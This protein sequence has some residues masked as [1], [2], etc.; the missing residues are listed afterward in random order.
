M[1]AQLFRHALA[2]HHRLHAIG[3]P[4]HA[5][6][7]AL[8]QQ[9]FHEGGISEDQVSISRSEEPHGGQDLAD[10]RSGRLDDPV[11]IEGQRHIEAGRPG[12]HGEGIDRDQRFGAKAIAR[13]EADVAVRDM[14]LGLGA[15]PV[16]GRSG[17]AAGFVDRR[18]D[19]RDAAVEAA[20]RQWVRVNV[21]VLVGLGKFLQDSRWHQ[22]IDRNAL[23]R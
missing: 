9:V 7:I 20:L 15:D 13:E 17:R 5:I 11:V 10:V 22:P 8:V 6:G 19:E 23:C 16:V 2:P 12:A 4:R 21:T 14:A 3:A 18:A 1:I